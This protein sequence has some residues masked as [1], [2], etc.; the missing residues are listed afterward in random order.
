MNHRHHRPHHPFSAS[1][2]G[3]DL[4]GLF[5]HLA[6]ALQEVPNVVTTAWAPKVR[7]KETAEAFV[8]QAEL[9][10]FESKD[11]EISTEK[12][13]LTIQG[14]RVKETSQ[15]GENVFRDERQYGRFSRSF[16]LPETAD[17]DAI[18]ASHRHGVLEVTIP[19]KAQTKP[20]R[21]DIEE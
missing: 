7:V 12:N 2:V 20:R 15:E 16:N 18:K 10:G 1:P 6:S 17:T 3:L 9:P 21:V 13:V 5:A 11:L 19:K 4:Q 8:I 14:E